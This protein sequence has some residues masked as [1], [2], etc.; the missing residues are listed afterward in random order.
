MNYN[1]ENDYFITSSI[2]AIPHCAAGYD[3]NMVDV[4]T[5][6]IYGSVYCI[7]CCYFKDGKEG[8]VMATAQTEATKRYAKKVGIIAKSY[9][10]PKKLADEFKETCDRVGVSQSQ[11]I[12]D[13]MTDFIKRNEKN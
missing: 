7:E 10:M 5:G 9:K 1:A 11:Q 12:R 13:M 6:Y 4:Y 2:I 8:R 3:W